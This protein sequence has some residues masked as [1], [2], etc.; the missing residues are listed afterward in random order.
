MGDVGEVVVVVGASREG[1]VSHMSLL[2]CNLSICLV[3][4]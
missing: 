4:S 2:I 1:S 3:G